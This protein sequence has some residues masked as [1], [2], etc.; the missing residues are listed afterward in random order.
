MPEGPREAVGGVYRVTR[1]RVVPGEECKDY[2]GRFFMR[3]FLDAGTLR[4]GHLVAEGVAESTEDD[5]RV[6]Y[7]RQRWLLRP[8]DMARVILKNPGL[9]PGYYVPLEAIRL[10]AGRHFV[11]ATDAS[12]PGEVGRAQKVEVKLTGELGEL[13]R[14]EAPELR[15]DLRLILKGVHYLLPDEPVVIAKEEVLS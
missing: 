10:E 4:A 8:G 13:R 6:V 15:P 7:E 3:Y 2:L 9:G 5:D 11:F 1:V 14:I 12:G